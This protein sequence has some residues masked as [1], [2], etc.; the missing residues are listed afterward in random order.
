MATETTPVAEVSRVA[1]KLPSFWEK[2]PELWFVNIE[3]QFKM[4]SITADSTQ[5]YA[6]IAALTADTLPHVSDIVLNPPSEN[7]Y[8]TVKERL[9]SEFTDSEQKRLRSLLSELSLGEDRPSL[10]LRK[11]RQLAGSKLNED[12]LKTL[13][14]QRLSP[15]TQA[16]LSV[17]NDTL[18]KLADMA[19]KIV[20]SSGAANPH[21]YAVSQSEVREEISELRQQIA[22]LTEQMRRFSQ[23][24][25]RDG[26]ARQRSRS[27]DR[28]NTSG[29]RSPQRERY[30]LCWYHARFGSRASKCRAPCKF[31]SQGN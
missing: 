6:V 30:D 5:Y 20:E 4:S 27:R 29:Y 12:L 16:I 19:D 10:L 11:M 17:S 21:C 18:E 2:S 24:R 7:M 3:A 13:W 25:A 26:N 31:E 22:E 1:L 9:I 23:P 28:P 8:K 15:Q 14:L